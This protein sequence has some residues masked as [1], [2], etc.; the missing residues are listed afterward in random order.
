MP[1]VAYTDQD[2]HLLQ[3]GFGLRVRAARQKLDISAAELGEHIGRSENFMWQVER[4]KA[5]VSLPVLLRL[6]GILQATPHDPLGW[7]S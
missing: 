6:C 1:R 5:L 4:G 3:P 7:D 2:R